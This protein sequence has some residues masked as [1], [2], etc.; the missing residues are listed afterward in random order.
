MRLHERP[1]AG[2]QGLFLQPQQG[3]GRRCRGIAIDVVVDGGKE[4]AVVWR[5]GGRG[6]L[7]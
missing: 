4:D 6:V 3:F 2:V 7:S 1:G 5:G